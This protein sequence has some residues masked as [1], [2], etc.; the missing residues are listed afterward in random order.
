MVRI[1][2]SATALWLLASGVIAAS[3]PSDGNTVP[4]HS[5]QSGDQ[6]QGDASTTAP[7]SGGESAL[8]SDGN[9]VPRA[10]SSGDSA[11]SGDTG[12]DSG[13][14][15]GSPLPGDGNVVP[16]GTGGTTPANP[17]HQESQPDDK[18]I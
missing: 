6:H 16:H 4:P 1:V 11:P 14:S 15:R 2:F 10:G 9:V 5:S 3:L 17:E 18:S 13:A 12:G 8:P 7:Q